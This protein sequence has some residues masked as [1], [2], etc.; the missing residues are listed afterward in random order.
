[1]DTKQVLIDEL[2]VFKGGRNAKKLEALINRTEAL[3]NVLSVPDLELN[4]ILLVLRVRKENMLSGDFV[5]CR[6][7]ATPV[8]EWL[9]GKIAWSYLECH[10]FS[11]MVSYTTTYTLAYTLAEKAVETLTSVHAHEKRYTAVIYSI[12]GNMT[13]RLLRAKYYDLKDPATPKSAKAE[14]EKLFTHYMKLVS[15]AARKSNFQVYLTVLEVR[16]ALFHNDSEA[17]TYGLQ[18]LK[19]TGDKEWYK[20]TCDEI[21]EYI[22]NLD[23]V[24]TSI[25]NLYI[26]RNVRRYRKRLGLSAQQLANALDTNVSVVYECESGRRGVSRTR[27][28]EIAKI[29]KVDISKLFGFEA[30][31]AAKPNIDPTT[32]AVLDI[33]ENLQEKKKKQILR[34]AKILTEDDDDNK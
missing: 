11:M 24:P 6:D 27:L 7:L 16:E 5:K 20:T 8:F 12:Y 34:L 29:L 2:F 15:T 4:N 25:H 14:V 19:Q 26:G 9:R 23:S 31:D 3:A 1:M 10:I 18:A 22:V 33:M 21:L 28:Y 30:H 32:E 13:Y 17:L